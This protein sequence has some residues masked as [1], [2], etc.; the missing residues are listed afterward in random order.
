MSTVMSQFAGLALKSRFPVIQLARGSDGKRR[1]VSLQ[2]VTGMD[3]DVITTNEIFHFRRISTD[4]ESVIHGHYETTGIRPKF[5]DDLATQGVHFSED[6][7][8][9]NRRLL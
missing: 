4:E 7:F 9:P 1:M 2:E 5:A 6:F 8:A 3:G